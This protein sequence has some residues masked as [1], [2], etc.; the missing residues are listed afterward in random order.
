MK[1]FD[2]ELRIDEIEAMSDDDIDFSDL[3]DTG[4]TLA[5]GWFVARG[6]LKDVLSRLSSS[7][8]ETVQPY[9]LS[10]AKANRRF[11][12]IASKQFDEERG[13]R[14]VAGRHGKSS[15]VSWNTRSSRQGI[16]T[17]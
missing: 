17:G 12:H 14:F 7:Q 3:P 5:E 4:D 16:A 13:V 8:S 15:F 11:V 6:G 1:R 10:P 2:R 9:T